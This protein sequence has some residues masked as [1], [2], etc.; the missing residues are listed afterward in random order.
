MPD[1]GRRIP[2]SLA[3]SDLLDHLRWL[4]ALTVLLGHARELLFPPFEQ[5][6]APSVAV[7]LFYFL[8][9]FQKEA[10]IVFFVLSGILICAK[11]GDYSRRSVFPVGRYVLDRL[12][13]LY[14]VLLPAV[15]VA[16]VPLATGACPS[17]GVWPWLASL[18]FLQDVAVPAPTCNEPMWSLANEFWYYA[19]SLL[20]VLGLRH[21]WAWLA[22]GGLAGMIFALDQGIDGRNVVLY[23]PVWASGALLLTARRL[24]PPLG[25]AAL[26]LAA[27]L[28][29]SRLH[30][31]DQWFWLRDFAIAVAVLA[32]IAALAARRVLVPDGAMARFG[33][34]MAAFS[35]SLYLTHWP[36]LLLMRQAFGEQDPAGLAA[37]GVYGAA[38]AAA[39]AFAYGFAALTERRTVWLRDWLATRFRPVPLAPQHQFGADADEGDAGQAVEPGLRHG[40]ARQALAQAAGEQAQQGEQ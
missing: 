22:A 3:M 39:L 36:L 16:L 18:V 6:E 17:D 24:R 19:L 12:T 35:Y 30:V 25:M 28:L 40:I 11:L 4:S 23:A 2:V 9:N 10:V 1:G 26:L 7:R 33:R 15:L 13:R 14:V 20:A 34:H 27:S 5:V 32:L 37:Y 29:A 31:L 21:R 38:V 8:T